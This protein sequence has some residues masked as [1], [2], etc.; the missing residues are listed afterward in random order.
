MKKLI[1]IAL[2]MIILSGCNNSEVESDT[3]SVEN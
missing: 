1:Y 3:T 2:F